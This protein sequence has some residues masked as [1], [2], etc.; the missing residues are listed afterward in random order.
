[1]YK[2]K[3]SSVVFL[4]FIV[5]LTQNV[6]SQ[7]DSSHFKKWSVSMLAGLYMDEN[8]NEFTISPNSGLDFEFHYTPS[9]AVYTNID[10][11]FLKISNEYYSN[12]TII[13]E[14]T[15]GTR[16]YLDPDFTRIFMELGFGY[17]QKFNHY[18]LQ[19]EGPGNNNDV[20]GINWGFGSDIKISSNVSV[21]LKVRFHFI[22]FLDNG[23]NT[24][25]WGI[26]SG[27]KYS[28]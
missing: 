27:I 22:D 5:F 6:F 26:Y 23:E 3:I 13:F 20:F 4:F 21:P 2:T 7:T 19:Y 10:F 1:M 11:N 16:W 12:T 15:M 8:K 18:G 25:Y 24:L 9:I 14:A 28:F 17:Y